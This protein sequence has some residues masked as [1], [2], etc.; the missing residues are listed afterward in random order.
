MCNRVENGL[1]LS[2]P[3]T[4]LLS[5][6]HY[7]NS[8]GLLPIDRSQMKEINYLNKLLGLLLPM[9]HLYHQLQRGNKTG[10]A[11]LSL[12]K[13]SNTEC[14]V[15]CSQIHPRIEYSSHIWNSFLLFILAIVAPRLC[16]RLLLVTSVT[17][18]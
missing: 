16:R 14:I 5:I 17:L 1:C 15:I 18:P 6:H 12:Q 4:K 8:F 3:K 2:T 13:L 11:I 10:R 9:G 7:Q